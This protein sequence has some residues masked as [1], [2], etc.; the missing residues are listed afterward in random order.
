MILDEALKPNEG[1]DVIVKHVTCTDNGGAA[2]GNR[3]LVMLGDVKKAEMSDAQRA[4]V[5]ARLLADLSQGR[6]WIHH[7]GEGSAL[8]DSSS[9]RGCSC[10]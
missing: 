2:G 1:R 8:V 6:V 9:I 7:D 3:W 5:F 10:C 4:L